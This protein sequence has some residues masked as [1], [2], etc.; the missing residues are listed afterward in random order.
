MVL[1]RSEQMAR[2]RGA[3]TSPEVALREALSTAGHTFDPK[4]RAPVGRPDIVFARE[5][6]AVFV[7]GC[8]WHGCPEHYTRPGSREEFWAARLASNTARDREQ[9]LALEAM[10][11]RVVRLWEHEVFSALSQCVTRVSES[12]SDPDWLPAG[13]EVVV[14][15]DV[16]DPTTRLER[17]HLEELRDPSVSRTVDHRRNTTKWKRRAS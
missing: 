9:T 11:W 12:M 8:F 7:D 13:R 14:R 5:K 10:D 4:G 2:I 16:L 15:V 6:V 17:H 3:D 1:S